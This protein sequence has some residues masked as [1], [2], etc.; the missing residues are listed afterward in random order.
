MW[1]LIASRS[2]GSRVSCCWHH[3]SYSLS[4]VGSPALPTC[5]IVWKIRV[6]AVVVL[7]LDDEQ[8][9]AQVRGDVDLDAAV[10]RLLHAGR[11][12]DVEALRAV[13]PLDRPHPRNCA[14]MPRMGAPEFS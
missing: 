14:R 2:A 5:T 6:P 3:F 11:G 13:D 7:H 10:L 1:L 4:S 9:V 12:Q 8:V